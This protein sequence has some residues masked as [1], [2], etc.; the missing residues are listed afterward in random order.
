MVGLYKDPNG[1]SIF[2]TKTQSA[3][4]QLNDVPSNELV[5]RL[6]KRIVELEN[7]KHSD[8]VIL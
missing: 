3:D 2:K 4:N 7:S 5:G 1:E 6:R 8:E